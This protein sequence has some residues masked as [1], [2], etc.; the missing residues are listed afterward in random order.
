MSTHY[1]VGSLLECED[2]G[3]NVMDLDLLGRV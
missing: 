3:T 1:A 2:V